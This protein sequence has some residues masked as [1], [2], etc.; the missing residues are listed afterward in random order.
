M[1]CHRMTARPTCAAP[2]ALIEGVFCP[3]CTPAVLQAVAHGAPAAIS[4]PMLWIGGITL[5]VAM[6]LGTDLVTTQASATTSDPAR[7]G[8]AA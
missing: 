5:A 4:R 8:E 6:G 2:M 1:P 7:A 3:C